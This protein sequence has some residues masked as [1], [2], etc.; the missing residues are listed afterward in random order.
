MGTLREEIDVKCPPHYLIHHVV[1]YFMVHRRDQTSGTFSLTVDISKVGLPGKVQARHD[2]RMRYKI[3]KGAN[4]QDEI[5]L[6]WDPDDRF[7]PKFAGALSGKRLES[8]ESRLTLGGQYNAPFGPMG[9]VF[10]VILG[11]R[12]A[13]ATASALLQDMKRFIELDYK[14]ALSTTLASSPKE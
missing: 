8:G 1:R 13:A 6:T 11:R 4:L 5:I 9:A 10:D 7:V 12:I 2:V 3:A 14:M